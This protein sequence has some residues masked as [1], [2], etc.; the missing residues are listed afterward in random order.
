LE[1]D[2]A[3][4]DSYPT[5]IA[6]PTRPHRTLDAT[7]EELA[8]EQAEEAAAAQQQAAAARRQAVYRADKNT[9]RA[10]WRQQRDSGKTPEQLALARV[11]R[12]R[13]NRGLA[14]LPG[15]PA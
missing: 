5:L 12:N 8:E 7:P 14:R 1:D 3:W 11:N 9:R 13:D 6:D 15:P 2:D 10:E 4:M